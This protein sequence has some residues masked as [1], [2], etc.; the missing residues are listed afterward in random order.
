MRKGKFIQGNVIKTAYGS[1]EIV[2][3][4]KDD[5]YTNTIPIDATNCSAGHRP[6]TYEDEVWCDCGSCEN[7]DSG[8]PYKTT[9]YGMDKAVL[10]ANTVK[11]WIIKSTTQ[12]FFE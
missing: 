9:M 1:I 10:V 5:G 3:S 6:D 7:C 12:K 8:K 4:V 2:T 11:E